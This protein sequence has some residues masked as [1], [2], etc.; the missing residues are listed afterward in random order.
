MGD[1]NKKTPIWLWI[2]SILLYSPLILAGFFCLALYTPFNYIQF[3]TS[4]YHKDFGGKFSFTRFGVHWDHKSYTMIKK[5]NL[6]IEYLKP[7]E[8]YESHGFF[9]YQ[10]A[11]LEFESPFW[12]DKEKEEWVSENYE[13]AEDEAV[14]TRNET[15]KNYLDFFHEKFPERKCEKVIFFMKKRDLEKSSGIAAVKAAQQIDNF[16]VYE[17]KLADAL[18]KF[19]NQA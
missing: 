7:D 5:N 16:V 19:V 15:V 4:R 17:G 12:Y 10:D 9:V 1:E 11:L 13:S 3:K 2:L 18:K 6:P 14:F 8:T